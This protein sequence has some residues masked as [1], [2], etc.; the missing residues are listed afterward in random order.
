MNVQHLFSNFLADRQVYDGAVRY[1]KGLAEEILRGKPASNTWVEWLNVKFADGTPFSDGNPI[2][3]MFSPCQQKGFS[4]QQMEPTNTEV[5]VNAWMKRFGADESTDSCY[6]EQMVIVCELSVE[7]TE[8]IRSLI[9][10]WTSEGMTYDGMVQF[11]AA[12]HL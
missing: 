5:Q 7:A 4:V 8:I 2:F 12:K 11:I 3:S 1:W 6:I 10:A 9:D